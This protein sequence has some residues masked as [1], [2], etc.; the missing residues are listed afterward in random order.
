[1]D[2]FQA[3]ELRRTYLVTY[4]QADLNK[5]PTQQ[6]FGKML[7][8]HFNGGSGMAKVTHL[9]CCLEEHQDKGL[10]Y[11]VSLKLTAPKKW[12][13]QFF[14]YCKF[15]KIQ[16]KYSFLDLLKQCSAKFNPVFLKLCVTVRSL[17]GFTT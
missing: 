15:V 9:A 14:I 12:I 6:S 7:E 4:S 16:G 13:Y 11:H 10:H 3:K 2:D 1:M 8:E 5:F 17:R